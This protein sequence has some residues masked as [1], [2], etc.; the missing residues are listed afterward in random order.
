[1][2]GLRWRDMIKPVED[3]LSKSVRCYEVLWFSLIG[4]LSGAQMAM[5]GEDLDLHT[6]NS[7]WVGEP[8]E[9]FKQWT[10]EFGVGI[11]AGFGMTVITSRGTHD[12][13]LGTLEYGWVISDV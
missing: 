10:K 2:G 5:G 6:T 13:V 4:L 12:W 11:G 3:Q 8:G 1:M 9:G 7:I